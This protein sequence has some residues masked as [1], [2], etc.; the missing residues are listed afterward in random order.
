VLRHQLE[1]LLEAGQLR[2]VE[3]QVMPMDRE[4]HAGLAGGT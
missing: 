3:L 2:N 1:H 4:E